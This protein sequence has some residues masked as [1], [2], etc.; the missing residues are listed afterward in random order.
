MGEETSFDMA[1]GERCYRICEQKAKCRN[2]ANSK[3]FTLKHFDVDSTSFG[4]AVDMLERKLTATDKMNLTNLR[5]YL[6]FVNIYR[7][8]RFNRKTYRTER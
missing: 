1:N 5:T 6:R 4:P 8:L 7:S 2:D 3:S